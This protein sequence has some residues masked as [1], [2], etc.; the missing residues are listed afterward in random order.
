M[1]LLIQTTPLDTFT[2]KC[3]DFLDNPTASAAMELDD[4]RVALRRYINTVKEIPELSAP[5]FDMGAMIREREM[6]KIQEVLNLVVE[7][8]K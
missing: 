8:I 5:L 7:K 1:S 3:Q 2:K 6:E 4:A